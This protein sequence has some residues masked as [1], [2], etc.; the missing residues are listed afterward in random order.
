[1]MLDTI[2]TIIVPCRP[3]IVR[4]CPG[5]KIGGLG[6]SRSVRISIAF[7]PAMK[8]NTPIPHRYCMPITLWSVLTVR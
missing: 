1:M 5:E 3:T 8:K 2:I 7:R 6:R 4:Y